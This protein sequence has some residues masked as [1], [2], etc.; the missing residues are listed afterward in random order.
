MME[1]LRALGTLDDEDCL[2]VGLNSGPVSRRLR[3]HGGAW[4]TMVTREGDRS[5][6]EQMVDGNVDTFDGGSFPHDDKCFD[7]VVVA[8]YLERAPNDSLL[9][10]ECHRVLKPSGRLI[11]CVSHAKRWTVLNPMRNLMGVSA[12]QRGWVRDG[13]TEAELFH[14]LKHC[15]DVHSVRSYSRFF[16]E[17]VDTLV[18]SH[19]TKIVEDQLGDDELVRLYSRWYPLY[20]TAFQLDFFLML[21]KG[22]K[23]VACAKRHGWRPRQAPVLNDGRSISEVVLS[24][25]KG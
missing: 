8:N 9:I 10:S 4:H 7:I 14:L 19:A 5:V 1:I 21:S 3:K 16:T 22:H 20:W 25:I 15:F 13:Y 2:D 11:L 17:L 18:L 6:V 24:K 23:L 12:V